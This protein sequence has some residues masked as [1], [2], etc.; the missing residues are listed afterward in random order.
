[1]IQVDPEIHQRNE[2]YVHD[3][4]EHGGT[5]KMNNNHTLFIH[6]FVTSGNYTSVPIPPGIVQF[7]SHPSKCNDNICAMSVPSVSDLIGFAKATLNDETKLHMIYTK[8]GTYVMM[9]SQ[10]FK[11][12]LQSDK[13]FARL[14]LN[15]VEYDLKFFRNKVRINKT[16]YI[17]FKEDWKNFI[18]KHGIKL[19]F[20]PIGTVPTFARDMFYI[21]PPSSPNTYVSILQQWALQLRPN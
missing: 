12:V 17:Q 3:M 19:L 1:M 21:S 4:V 18:L 9:L 20:L 15:K 14:W 16:N 6:D 10:H 13:N 5:L 8:D 2:N 7:H 11:K